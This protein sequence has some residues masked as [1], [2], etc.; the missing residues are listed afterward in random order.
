LCPKVERLVIQAEKE[1]PR[2]VCGQGTLGKQLSMISWLGLKE[3]FIFLKLSIGIES[4]LMPNL[5]HLLTHQSASELL[6]SSW[7]IE[8]FSLPLDNCPGFRHQM[9]G[10][11]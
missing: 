7:E 1:G 8:G 11:R 3:L 10:R 2:E 5:H 9:L 4:A 6:C